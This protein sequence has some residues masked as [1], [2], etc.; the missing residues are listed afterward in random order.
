MLT[1]AGA[2]DRALPNGSHAGR[3]LVG[4]GAIREKT[5]IAEAISPLFCPFFSS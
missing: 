2:F 3:S 1:D 4:G 5:R